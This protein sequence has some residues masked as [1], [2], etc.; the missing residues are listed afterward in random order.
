MLA[1]KRYLFL[2]LERG[3]FGGRGV[4]ALVGGKEE[5]NQVVSFSH[6]FLGRDKSPTSSLINPQVSERGT[7][8]VLV[9]KE[10]LFTFLF[11]EMVRGS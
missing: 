11:R 9:E 6:F 1:P 10:N 3:R 7:K 2:D 5:G 4:S 8:E